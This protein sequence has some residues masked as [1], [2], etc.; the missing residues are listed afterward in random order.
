MY[1]ENQYHSP[2]YLKAAYM[3][4]HSSILVVCICYCLYDGFICLQIAQVP[5][6]LLKFLAGVIFL[7]VD[8][9]YVVAMVY[10]D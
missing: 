3:I 9:E 2:F 10:E 5:F 6:Y 1:R 8:V 7:C 4:F